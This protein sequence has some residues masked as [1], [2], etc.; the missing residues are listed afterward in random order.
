MIKSFKNKKL[1]KFFITGSLA[2]INP[3]HAKKLRMV[4]ALLDSAHVVVDMDAPGL[5]FHE[6]VGNRKGV[7]SVTINGNW[8]ITFEFYEGDAYIVNYEDYH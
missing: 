8:R 6:L 2:G 1:E 4:L 3:Q 5:R 7:Y